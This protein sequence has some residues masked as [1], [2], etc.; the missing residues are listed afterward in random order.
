MPQPPRQVREVRDP[1]D[2]QYD[3][4]GPEHREDR[5][6][7]DAF[8]RWS[9]RSSH[10]TKYVALYARGGCN[11]DLTGAR[12]RTR[13]E[14]RSRWRRRRGRRCAQVVRH[15][16]GPA[17]RVAASRRARVRHDHRP[18]G[19]GQKH[20]SEPDREPRA[21]RLRHRHRRRGAVP[22]P[23]TQSSSGGGWSASCSRTTCCCRT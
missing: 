8:P 6:D 23:A 15:G 22:D 1:P 16:R 18:I 3:S 2:Q 13:V 10:A 4:A 11:P 20:A 19:F 9:L 5:H 12:R 14:H 7:R 17:R 21:A